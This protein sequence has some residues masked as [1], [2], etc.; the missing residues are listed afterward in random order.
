MSNFSTPPLTRGR[1]HVLCIRPVRSRLVLVEHCLRDTPCSWFQM[2][3]DTI[4]VEVYS[5]TA[6]LSHE[7]GCGWRF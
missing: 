3:P 6:T 7:T 2:G 4:L 1:S 5:S